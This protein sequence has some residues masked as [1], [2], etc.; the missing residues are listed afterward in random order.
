MFVVV[1]TI[2][3][4]DRDGDG[5]SWWTHTCPQLFPTRTKANNYVRDVYAESIVNSHKGE[6]FTM[7]FKD[8]VKGDDD[9]VR[10]GDC[11]AFTW[12]HEGDDFDDFLVVYVTEVSM[13]A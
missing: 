8:M 6:I 9:E 2:S 4:D 7:S 13:K 11:H 1:S 12:Y 3:S 10:E 5:E